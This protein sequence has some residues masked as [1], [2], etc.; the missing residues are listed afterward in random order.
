MTVTA[1][2]VTR[3]KVHAPYMDLL[4]K[5]EYLLEKLKHDGRMQDEAE[6]GTCKQSATNANLNQLTELKWSDNFENL[7][8]H[9]CLASTVES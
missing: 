5:V 8:F 6:Q 7:P 1:I 3:M 4:T 2:H 9:E